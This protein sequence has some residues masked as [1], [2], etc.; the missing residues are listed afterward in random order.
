MNDR[1]EQRIAETGPPTPEPSDRVFRIAWPFHP[2]YFGIR[3]IADADEL[4]QAIGKDTEAA[5]LEGM[6]RL[7]GEGMRVLVLEAEPREIA[8]FVRMMA[9]ASANARPEGRS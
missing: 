6:K 5:V 1:I 4:E 8:T 7:V 9:Q 2:S 3:I